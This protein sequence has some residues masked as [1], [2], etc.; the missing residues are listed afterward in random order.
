MSKNEIKKYLLIL[1]TLIVSLT[2]CVTAPVT[3][4]A[5]ADTNGFYINRFFQK[6]TIP[7][8]ST[9]GIINSGVN[10]TFFISAAL[11]E[12]GL[13]VRQLDLY[14]MIDKDSLS[15]VNVDKKDTS[16]VKK[17]TSQNKGPE[18]SSSSMDVDTLITSLYEVDD[19]VIENQR[20]K[21][22]SELKETLKELIKNMGVD[23]IIVTEKRYVE[24]HYE[25]SIY[26]T[27]NMNLI[28]SHFI[29]ADVKQWR[30][31]V[32]QPMQNENLSYKF[33]DDS[34][35]LPFYDL[36]YAEFMANLLEIAE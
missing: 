16:I 6:E 27:S 23:Y 26:K 24:H 8:G 3:V 1:I 12:K 17:I 25:T 22:Y 2:S 29:V 9:V 4:K 10:N 19:L 14:S 11:Q 33:N 18:D 35:P 28:F 15:K 34:E 13:N 30:D 36:T 20:A 31:Y 5:A 21:H 7:I 32:T